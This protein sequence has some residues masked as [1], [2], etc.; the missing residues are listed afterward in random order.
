MIILLGLGN[1]GD[2]YKENRHNVGFMFVDWLH[3]ETYNA[4]R[5]SWKYDKYSDSETAKITLHMKRTVLHAVLAKPQTYMNRSGFTANK[6][7]STLHATQTT[8]YVVHDDLDIRLGEFKIT[9]GKGP[10][11]HNGL[12]SIESSLR[13]KNFWRIRI[14]IDNRDP[15]RRIPGEPYVLQNF[16][17][18]EKESISQTFPIILQKL[19]SVFEAQQQS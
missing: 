19:Q 1:P 9:Q 8:L 5:N 13:F 11:V 10:K 4:E 3:R 17:N 15:K 12:A 16:S 2:Q 14:G 7:L 18:E 6:L